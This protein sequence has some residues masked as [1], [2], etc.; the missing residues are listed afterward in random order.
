MCL[1]QCGSSFLNPLSSLLLLVFPSKGRLSSGV[2]PNPAQPTQ[3]RDNNIYAHA[4]WAF[5]DNQ[6][7]EGVTF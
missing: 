7:C 2:S 6:Q 4:R 5:L 1:I 3:P